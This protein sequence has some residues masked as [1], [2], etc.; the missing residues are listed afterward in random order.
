MKKIAI[1]KK[2][3]VYPMAVSLVGA[4]VE[5]KPNF[6]TVV[7]WSIVNFQPPLIAVV[8]N[9]NHYTNRG[10]QESKTFSI[11]IPSEDMVSLVDYCSIF[12][13][14]EADKSTI[15]ATFYGS[16]KT[17]PMISE[18][19]I[20]VECKLIETLGFATHD[21]FIGEIVEAYTE[22]KYLTSD[23]LDIKKVNPIIY[24]MY[25]NYYWKL[26]KNIGKAYHI[27]KKYKPKEK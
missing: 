13:G 8:L 24:T 2:I 21:I 6:L 23:V 4:Q 14:R 15:F 27:G 19:P 5:G 12:S 1:E 3:P 16:L 11:N 20:T 25:D 10:I 7:W 9:K 26:G 22:K 18:C 17:A